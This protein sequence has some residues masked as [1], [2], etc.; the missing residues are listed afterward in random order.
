MKKCLLACA[1][2][3]LPGRW[4]G[5]P[6]SIFVYTQNCAKAVDIFASTDELTLVDTST[7]A[8]GSSGKKNTIRDPVLNLVNEVLGVYGV[9]T[10]F[11]LSMPRHPT[12]QK[13]RP[14]Y[15]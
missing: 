6:E 13:I 15:R 14:K 8:N 2:S 7:F 10:F 5:D 4:K 9:P 11:S 12:Y 3:P 1:I